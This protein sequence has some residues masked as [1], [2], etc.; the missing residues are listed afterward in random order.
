M[1]EIR[2]T[3]SGQLRWQ[4]VSGES[5]APEFAKLQ[6]SFEQ[7]WPQGLFKLAAD[8]YKTTNSLTLGYWQGLAEHY[9][10]GLCHIP[11]SVDDIVVEPPSD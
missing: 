3:P 7:D 10:T 11:E 6:K 2:L 4:T 1:N 8:K 9:L 5:R